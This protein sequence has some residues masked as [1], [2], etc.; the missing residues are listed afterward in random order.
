MSAALR[1]KAEP[2]QYCKR[3]SWHCEDVDLSVANPR[4]GEWYIYDVR[5]AADVGKIIVDA[6]NAAA[7]RADTWG[8]S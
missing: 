7:D 5:V 6:V 1:L 3:R 8:Q 4:D 2:C